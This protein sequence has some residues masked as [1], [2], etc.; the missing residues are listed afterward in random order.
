MVILKECK[1]QERSKQYTPGNPFQRGQWGDQ[2]Y[3][4]RMM[5]KDIQR[6]K[7]PNWKTLVQKRGRWK[8]L[9]RPKLC[10]KSC[11]VV[12]KEVLSFGATTNMVYVCVH[13]YI[14]IYIH[15]YTIIFDFQVTVHREKFL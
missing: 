6:L 7:V 13:T 1:I 11:R 2:K 3:A 10:T 5:L 15:T 14:H 12:L 9:G 4:G 8:W